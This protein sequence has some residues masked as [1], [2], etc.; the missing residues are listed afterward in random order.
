MSQVNSL[1]KRGEGKANERRD[2]GRKTGK[3]NARSSE[4][5]LKGASGRFAYSADS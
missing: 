3:M 2:G 4:I 1:I 5:H